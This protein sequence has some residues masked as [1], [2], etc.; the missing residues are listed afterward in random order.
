LRK[1]ARTFEEVLGGGAI[2][3]QKGPPA[4]GCVAMVGGRG[5]D[6]RERGGYAHLRRI[7]DQELQKWRGVR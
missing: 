5:G 6:A 3:K 2:L 1:G 7:R 4:A